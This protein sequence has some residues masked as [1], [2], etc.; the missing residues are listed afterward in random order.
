[1]AEKEESAITPTSGVTILEDLPM[2]SAAGKRPRESPGEENPVVKLRLET[3][4]DE[5]RTAA[6]PRYCEKEELMRRVHD[7]AKAISALV[8]GPGSKLN[9]A[10]ISNVAAYGHEILA[11]VAALNLRLAEAE[12]QPPSYA[13]AFRLPR[14]EQAETI[15][16]SESGPVLAIYP[17]AELENIKTAED[18]KQLLKSAIDPASMQVQVT[19]VRKVGRAGVVVQTTSAESADKIRKAVPPTL[20]VTEP[21]SRKP[22]VALRNMLGDPSNEDIF[23]GLYEQ[24]LRVRDPTWTLERLKKACRIAFRSRRDRPITT[25]WYWSAARNCEICWCQW[26][27]FHRLGGGTV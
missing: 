25:W 21:R 18:T 3:D 2:G 11:V 27:A 12:L 19:K 17:V 9:K 8:A 1:M 26:I 22:L 4:S 16:K 14:R 20:R 13:S 15:R 6:V 5:E 10:D 23:T 24:N 7:S